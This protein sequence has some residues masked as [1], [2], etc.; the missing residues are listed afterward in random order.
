MHQFVRQDLHFKMQSLKNVI[1]LND[2][3]KLGWYK[4]I[5]KKKNDFSN[6]FKQLLNEFPSVFGTQMAFLVFIFRF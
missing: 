3:K 4:K 1:F 5:L 6:S 2:S